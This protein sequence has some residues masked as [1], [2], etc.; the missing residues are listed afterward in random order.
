MLEASNSGPV[1][2]LERATDIYL[3]ELMATEDA[4]EDLRAFGEKRSPEWRHR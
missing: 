4:L 3:E 1:V 2:G